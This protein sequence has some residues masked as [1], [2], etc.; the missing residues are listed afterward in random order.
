MQQLTDHALDPPGTRGDDSGDTAAIAESDSRTLILAVEEAEAEAEA[1]E[2]AAEAARAR[3]RAARLRRHA[4][5]TTAAHGRAA[6]ASTGSG[7]PETV[8]ADTAATEAGESATD[9]ADTVDAS[10][11]EDPVSTEDTSAEATSTEDA[12]TEDAATEATAATA[13]TDD[14]AA[15][16]DAPAVP[17]EHNA[18]PVIRG[19]RRRIAVISTAVALIVAAFAVSGF[20][21]WHHHQLTQEQRRTAEFTAAARQGVVALTT[22]DFNH[23][24]E[25]VQRVLDNST[26]SFREDFK[27]RAEDFTTVIRQSQVSTEGAVNG[28]AVESM[29][30]DTAVVLVAATSQVTNSAGAKQE[31]RAW[32]LSVTVTRVDGQIKMSKV[33]FVP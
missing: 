4:A 26:G 11:A 29:T 12:A 20:S 24:P 2:A 15:T 19:R 23:A 14:D 9:R 7:R 28:V 6:E 18:A 10:A 22:L 33:E 3:A 32:R 25:D 16:D 27:S 5:S 31:P 1:A 17:L 13:I 8:G 30:E 21:V